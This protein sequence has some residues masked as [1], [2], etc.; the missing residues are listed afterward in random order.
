[1]N[2][3]ARLF[4]TEGWTETG[5]VGNEAAL[6]VAFSPDDR[7]LLTAGPR[8]IAWDLT[9]AVRNPDPCVKSAPADPDSFIVVDQNAGS[10]Y[11]LSFS[12]EG[13]WLVE[14]S[15]LR[16][17]LHSDFV[18]GNGL[19]SVPLSDLGQNKKFGV[20]DKLDFS[21]NPIVAV[22]S[23]AGFAATGGSGEIAIWRADVERKQFQEL[24][25]ILAST[26][27]F[28]PTGNWLIGAADDRLERWDL[29]AGA[30][31]RR[32]RHGAGVLDVAV[33]PDARFLATTTADGS[34][35]V[36]ETNTWREIFKDEIHR[37]EGG[38]A[39]SNI[40]FSADG[41]W[42]AATSQNVVKIF[43]TNDWRQVASRDLENAI[44]SAVFSS[45]SKWL[46]VNANPELALIA[47]NSWLTSHF[48]HEGADAVSISPDGRQLLISHKP[49]C[50]R[51]HQV[52]GL[53]QVWEIASGQK[54]GETSLTDNSCGGVEQQDQKPSGAL[55]DTNWRDWEAHSGERRIA[56]R[57]G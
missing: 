7:W 49:R 51:A 19:R 53:A 15:G 24:G 38:T 20:G 54:Q 16:S 44:H 40:A 18:D 12:G 42:L 23:D 43:S 30:E 13:R 4:E 17:V 52:A 1:M 47:V 33:T 36:W 10:H 45:D 34:A 57:M 26:V 5:R 28:A 14:G 22:S 2:Y 11:F 21:R 27:A 55:Q 37:T 9:S 6:A 3:C 46:V 32:L 35:H 56:K 41:H 39:K 25:R 48:V 29:A 31:W 50:Q 8:V